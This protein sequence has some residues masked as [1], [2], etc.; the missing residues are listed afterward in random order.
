[1]AKT[2]IDILVT[3]LCNRIGW[4]TAGSTQ[5][6]DALKE[7]DR[8]EKYIQQRHSLLNL[9]YATTATLNNNS[10]QVAMPS[11]FDYGKDVIVQDS[12]SGD[13]LEY[14]PPSD[15]WDSDQ[16]SYGDWK[17]TRP[18]GFTFFGDG[19]G[20][21]FINF[22]PKNMTG[23]G[24]TYNIL[25]QRTLITL[26]DANNGVGST[27]LLPEGFETTLLLNRAEAV[28]KR[29]LRRAGWEELMQTVE[30]DIEAFYAS[31]RAS[32]EEAMTDREQKERKI[33]ATQ[34]AEG[35]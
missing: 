20:V 25:G 19:T 18:E 15:W 11:N 5:R 16:D 14:I 2:T 3:E 35:V 26:I 9:M 34:F 6:A 28:L 30:G 4:D 33:A 24:L 12:A 8:A 7:L 17:A 22:R 32:K 21:M 1:M 29:V 31:Y 27:S 10:S 13:Q 23:G